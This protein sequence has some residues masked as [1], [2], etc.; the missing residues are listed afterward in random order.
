MQIYIETKDV[1]LK[2]FSIIRASERVK[3]PGMALGNGKD[4]GRL[5][6][7]SWLEGIQIY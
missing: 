4:S 6:S 3:L 7:V 2:P 1:S 5:G